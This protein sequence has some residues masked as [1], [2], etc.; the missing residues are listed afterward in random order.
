MSNERICARYKIH[1]VIQRK[2]MIE[3]SLV[4]HEA[5]NFIPC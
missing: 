2:F 1:T 3:I 4:E 5:L